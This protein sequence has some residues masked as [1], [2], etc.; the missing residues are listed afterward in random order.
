VGYDRGYGVTRFL[1]FRFRFSFFVFR[2][3]FQFPYASSLLVADT[4]ASVSRFSLL[5]SANSVKM[6]VWRV[7]V[8]FSRLRLVC[9]DRAGGWLLCLSCFLLFH[10]ASINIIS[11]HRNC[12]HTSPDTNT[13]PTNPSLS[14]ALFLCWTAHGGGRREE[15]RSPGDRQQEEKLQNAKSNEATTKQRSNEAT[16]QNSKTRNTKTNQ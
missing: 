14:T 8:Y 4:H 6:S 15:S 12:R 11:N 7:I 5:G 10:N 16:K 3:R 13:H 9:L 2:F 1:V